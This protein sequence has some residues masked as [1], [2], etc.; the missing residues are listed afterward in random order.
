MG[1][2]LF[3]YVTGGVAA[4]DLKVTE[5]AFASGTK[6]HTGWTAGGGLEKAIDHR[7]SV[8]L[9]YLYTDLGEKTHFQVDG[10]DHKADFI[11]SV[12][13]LGVNIRPW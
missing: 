13:R 10:N 11:A 9:E 12:V 5:S 2:G 4:G 3:G 7:W 1:G 6:W 8:K